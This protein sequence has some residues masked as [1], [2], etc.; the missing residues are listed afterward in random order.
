MIYLKPKGN[1]RL[2]YFLLL[3]ITLVL[4]INQGCASL[5]S[6]QFVA[7]SERPPEYERFFDQLD[8]AVDDADVKDAAAFSVPGFPYLRANRFLASLKDPLTDDRQKEQWV[9]WM[10]QLDLEA[11]R[12]EIFNLPQDQFENLTWHMGE[13]FDRFALMQRVKFYSDRLLLH[14]QRHPD[15]YATLHKA[16]VIPDEYSTTM[17]VI[18]IYPL[19]SLPVALVTHGVYDDMRDWHQLPRD[20]LVTRGEIR[21]YG[22]ARHTAYSQQKIRA[23][24]KRSEQNPL[25][26]P[27]PSGS[28]RQILLA[29]FAP[30]FFQD[31]AADYDEIGEVA[32]KDNLVTVN[33]AKPTV[34]YF[35]SYARFKTVP[36]LQINYVV[37]YSSRDGPN[38]PW[39]ERGPLD[40]ITVR[41]SLDPE[42]RP[43]MIDI[44]NNCGCYHFFVPSK[45][46]GQY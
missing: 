28:D 11:R 22:P 5:V 38:S 25:G 29:T 23:I 32:W 2:H 3:A 41:I 12:K 30:L 34:Y 45:E 14:D 24:L 20:E 4:V 18:G 9:R 19:T 17:R 42:G 35:F 7:E 13:R 8:Q 21:G 31:V 15:F 36:I 16:V 44:M 43:F 33:S 27:L 10:Q 26:I 40:G 1:M 46:R 39:I 6:W 37:W